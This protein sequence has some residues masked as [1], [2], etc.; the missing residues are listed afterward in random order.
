MVYSAPAVARFDG[1]LGGNRVLFCDQPFPT[2]GEQTPLHFVKI[3]TAARKTDRTGQGSSICKDALEGKESRQ[4]ASVEHERI[5]SYHFLIQRRSIW[6]FEIS[7]ANTDLPTELELQEK[8]GCVAIGLALNDYPTVSAQPGWRYGSFAYHSDDG[9]KFRGQSMGTKYGPKFGRGDTVGCGVD[10][11]SR[12]IFFTL[13]GEALPIAWYWTPESNE[14]FFPVVGVDTHRNVEVNFGLKPFLYNFCSTPQPPASSSSAD[15]SLS[16]SDFYSS[17]DE[18]QDFFQTLGADMIQSILEQY[19]NLDAMQGDPVGVEIE[20]HED[21]DEYD[22]ARGE[23]YARFGNDHYHESSETED[24][25][26]HRGNVSGSSTSSRDGDSPMD[27]LSE[28]D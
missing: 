18:E 11:L 6:Y 25:E 23:R 4:S 5:Y 22:E 17:S 16:G 2:F 26:E 1:V 14:T 12:S 8:Y 3:E 27:T 7:I 20:Y 28:E 9:R 19:A 24:S 13:N 10:Y 21:S 15:E